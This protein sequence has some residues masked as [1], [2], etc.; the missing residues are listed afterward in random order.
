[1]LACG[2]AVSVPA[3]RT[4]ASPIAHQLVESASPPIFDIFLD[5]LMAA[6]SGGR[7]H[8]KNPR[9][10]AL[11]P[12]QFIKSTFLDVTRR[13]FPA[14]IAGLTEE[15]ILRMRTD[16]N[17]SRRVAAI[18]CKE[19]FGHLKAR[20]L[21]PTFAH[22]RLAYLLGPADAAQLMEVK[23][24]TPVVELLSAAVIRANPFMRSMTVADLFAR[25][26]GTWKGASCSKPRRN[27]VRVPLRRPGPRSSTA[28]L[29]QPSGAMQS[30]PH[31]SGLSSDPRSL[32]Q[33]TSRKV[34]VALAERRFKTAG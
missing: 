23:A 30:W 21:E 22:L 14:E 34:H 28:P 26:N 4:S 13:H 10:S 33:V 31:V 6:E 3:S 7:P 20:G 29:K 17:L 16:L 25:A 24:Q 1:M 2:L 15:Q 8:A 27:L 5:R 9:S 19:I 32:E 18:Y 11:G 12:Y